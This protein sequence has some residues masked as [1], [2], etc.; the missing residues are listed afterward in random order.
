MTEEKLRKAIEKLEE[1]RQLTEDLLL[2]A[3]L[4]L[5]E[6]GVK[7]KTNQLLEKAKNHRPK[8]TVYK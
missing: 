5:D 6:L 8:R 3:L 2:G 7:P 1:Q 4:M